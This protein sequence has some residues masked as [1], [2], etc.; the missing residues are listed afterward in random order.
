MGWKLSA[1]TGSTACPSLA[2]AALDNCD[3]TPIRRSVAVLAAMQ[4][5][6]FSTELK[7]FSYG[8]QPSVK[9]LHDLKTWVEDLDWVVEQLLT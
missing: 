4:R 5:N 9:A 6:R 8:D 2:G 7:A 1:A 3:V